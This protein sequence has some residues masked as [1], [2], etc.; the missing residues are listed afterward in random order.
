V[1][2][3]DTFAGGHEH[4]GIAELAKLVE[5]YGPLPRTLRAE[6][7]SGSQH[8]Y[9][10]HP[11]DA[12]VR[13]STGDIAPGIDTRG[14]GGM[15][16]AP[17][18]RKGDGTYRWIDNGLVSEAPEW[19][20]ALAP[21]VGSS[22]ASARAN[23]APVGGI[24]GEAPGWIRAEDCGHGVEPLP[25]IAELRAAVKAIPNTELDWEE[26]NNMGLR[27]YAASGGSAEGLE[28]FEDWSDKL[29]D[30]PAKDNAAARWKHF[31]KYP[32]DR[33]GFDKLELLA[34]EADPNWR[35]T[36]DH[37]EEA[38]KGPTE[39]AGRGIPFMITHEM[40]A[41]LAENGFTPE[42]VREMTPESAWE[43]LRAR[44]WT[45]ASE[46]TGPERAGPVSQNSGPLPELIIDGGDLTKTAKQLAKMFARHRRFLFNGNE[47]IQVVRENDEMPK[48]VMATSEA[49][50]VFCH[51]ICIPKKYDKRAGRLVRVTLSAGIAN[52]YL[53]GLQ[54]QWGLRPFQGLTTAPILSDDGSFRTSSGYDETTGLWCHQIPA[55]D[56]PERPTWAQAK[57]S[58][59]A[60]R[61][62]F[63][64]FAFADATVIRDRDLG[65]NVVNLDGPIGL[66]E[67]TFLASLMTAVCRSSLVL[68]P[69][70][71]ANAPAFS[72]AGTGKGLGMKAICIIASVA[73][74]RAFTAG[75]DEG[76][77]DKR[78]T[79]A[80]VEARPAVFL[81]N[82]NSKA[83][84]SDILASAL[85]ENPCEVRPFG[86]TTMIKLYTRTLV[87]ITGNA[88]QVA[89]DMAR[90][91][92]VT[93]FDAK[94]EH[95]ELRPF[96]PG[97][98][99]TVYKA[100]GA[101]L[102]HA[103]T[104]WRWGRQNAGVLKR[105]KPLGS[106]EVW[107]EWCR[108]PLITLGARDPADRLE[109]IKDVDPR[110][111]SV[112]AVFEIWWE[113]HRNRPMLVKDLDQR[114][115]EAIDLKAKRFAGVLEHNR[116][117]VARWLPQH[118]GTRIGGYVLSAEISGP[119]SKP[120]N[121]YRLD[122]GPDG[123][124]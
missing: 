91:V 40:R 47:P 74:P 11:P 66:D 14:Q 54:G 5:R 73:P 108:D 53:R 85:T 23:G 36:I 20:L 50:R 60:L 88:V 27:L 114:V 76:E 103:L 49:V 35:S 59:A 31:H 30:N 65:V 81:D 110:R 69:G 38:G 71:L 89:E 46:R 67:S 2:D 39:G 7:P 82:F 77:L 90:R 32:P 18:S 104:I 52:L 62:F 26:W 45:L 55:V 6:S 25:S 102:G 10:R 1:L 44:G 4:D 29:E 12:P 51:E 99:D 61:R 21:R 101:L 33:T 107:R 84:T 80:L 86:Y 16:V 98:L 122:K 17:P 95:P 41:A 70:I 43:A 37:H 123:E 124:V 119:K 9:F 28:I 8:Y 109:A 105:G 120:V 87:A 19:L 94:V 56:V 48:A 68:A 115:I 42:Q 118:V 121:M 58:L 22:K 75:H 34:R 96:K 13:N 116:Q 93:N 100:R 106:Y 15:V 78:L 57:A 92:I 79:S 24:I 117:F 112:L 97:F 64:T 111:K 113:R 72:G 83:L 3:C 63:R